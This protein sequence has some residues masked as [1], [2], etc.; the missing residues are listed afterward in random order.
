MYV[1]END[2]KQA[3]CPATTSVD[4]IAKD[5]TCYYVNHWD[6]ECGSRETKNLRFRIGMGTTCMIPPNAATSCASMMR[7]PCGADS[8]WSS[9]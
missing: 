4:E 6:I 9:R 1:Q 3:W 8:A 5:H 7:L 2:M